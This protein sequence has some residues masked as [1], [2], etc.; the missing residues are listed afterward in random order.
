MRERLR[1][2]EDRLRMLLDAVHDYAEQLIADMLD[3]SRIVTGKLR[4]TPGPVHRAPYRGKAARLA[5]GVQI[6]RG[7]HR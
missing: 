6:D 3:V 4:L 5:A 7:N 1:Q 2:A